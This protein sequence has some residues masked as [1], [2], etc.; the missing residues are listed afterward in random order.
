M[1][2]KKQDADEYKPYDIIYNQYRNT[3]HFTRCFSFINTNLTLQQ[4]AEE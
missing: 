2:V 1:H 3:E 4:K